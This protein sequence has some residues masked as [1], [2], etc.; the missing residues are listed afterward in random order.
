MTEMEHEIMKNQIEG[1]KRD[2]PE[3]QWAEEITSMLRDAYRQGYSA[4]RR[5]AE[6]GD[7]AY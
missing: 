3:E 7:A 2:Y 1:I 5:A 4:G 6:A